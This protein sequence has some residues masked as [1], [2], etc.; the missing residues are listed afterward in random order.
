M[1]MIIVCGSGELRLIIRMVRCFA[2]EKKRTLLNGMNACAYKK[3][4]AVKAER[5]LDV[6][7][8]F[9]LAFSCYLI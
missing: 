1:Q 5:M 8:S 4:N 7:G 2:R 6:V 9:L 3:K